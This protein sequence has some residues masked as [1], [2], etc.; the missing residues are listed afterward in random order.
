MTKKKLLLSIAALVLAGTLVSFHFIDQW[1][2]IQDRPE[3][4]DVIICLGGGTGERLQKTIELYKK[5]YAPRV[6]LTVSGIRDPEF[7]AFAIDLKRQFLIHKGIPPGSI[8]SEFES[9][10]TYSEA[11]NIENFMTSNNLHSAIVVSDAHHMRRVS[12]VFKKV[13][14]KGNDNMKV[15]FV[16]SDKKWPEGPWW[17]NEESLVFVFN[18]VLKLGY[19]WVKY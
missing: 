15:L 18:E 6:V 9:T 3:K 13:F 2:V 1:L 8:V 4:V 17:T 14:D 5:G 10:G 7:R 11:K 16:P 12:Y 19:Y